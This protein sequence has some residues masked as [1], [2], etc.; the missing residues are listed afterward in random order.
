MDDH[1]GK[2]RED[3]LLSSTLH[4]TRNLQKGKVLPY[5]VPNVWDSENTLIKFL[6]LPKFNFL[7]F[8]MPA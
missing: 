3:T 7:S 5:L 2:V 4:Q 1:Q 8:A 6:N